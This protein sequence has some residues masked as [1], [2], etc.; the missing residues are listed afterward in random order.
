MKPIFWYLLIFIAGVVSGLG[1]AK[2]DDNTN[3]NV[4]VVVINKADQS[5]SSIQLKTARTGKNIHL[6]GIQRGSQLT[7]KFHNEGEDRFTLVIQFQDGRELRG[8][9]VYIEPGY[10][11]LESVTDHGIATEHELPD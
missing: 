9:P 8:N 2:F 4:E 10:R 6:R 3:P 5:I 11:I 7:I 1:L